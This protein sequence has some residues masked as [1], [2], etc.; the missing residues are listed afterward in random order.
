MNVSTCPPHC[1]CHN[2]PGPDA[3]Y[4]EHLRHRPGLA[5]YAWTHPRTPHVAA[6]RFSPKPHQAWAASEDR[7]DGSRIAC[8]DTRKPHGHHP[9]RREG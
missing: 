4:A 3:P 7:P 2:R 1:P 8:F 9:P 6:S 5:H